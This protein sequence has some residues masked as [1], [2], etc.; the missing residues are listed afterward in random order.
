MVKVRAKSGDV[1]MLWV[2]QAPRHL[3]RV[4]AE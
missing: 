3:K 2:F 4:V 1:V